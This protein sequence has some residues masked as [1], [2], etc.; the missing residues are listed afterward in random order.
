[1]AIFCLEQ[2]SSLIL[3]QYIQDPAR[4]GTV[5]SLMATP[6]MNF[7]AGVELRFAISPFDVLL[8]MDANNF[9]RR[10]HGLRNSTADLFDESFLEAVRLRPARCTSEAVPVDFDLRRS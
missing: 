9:H 10:A 8:E 7:S 5:F 6:L 2:A 1:M 4:D 3:S